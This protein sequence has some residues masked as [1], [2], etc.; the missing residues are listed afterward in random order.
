MRWRDGERI[1]IIRRDESL[2]RNKNHNSYSK[3]SR[4]LCG[5]LPQDKTIHTI[6]DGSVLR[7]VL[8]TLTEWVICQPCYFEYAARK[9]IAAMC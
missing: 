7:C 3:Q 1:C 4:F 9:Q 8:F 2:R 6:T 5:W